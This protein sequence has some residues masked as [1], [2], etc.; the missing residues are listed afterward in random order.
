VI[1]RTAESDLPECSGV[2]KGNKISQSSPAFAD[3]GVPTRFLKQLDHAGVHTPFPIQAAVLPDAYAGR[4]IA[5][6]APT[7]SGKTLAFGLPLVTNVG[8]AKRRAPTGLVLA[9][10]RELAGQIADA[11]RPLAAVEGRTVTAVFGGVGYGPQR[12][13]LNN[14][15][16]IVVACPGRLEDL[17]DQRALRLDAVEVLVV[18]EADRMADMGFLPAIRRILGAATA[19]RQTMLF[20]ATLDGAVRK[21]IR[22]L[23]LDCVAHEIDA[24]EDELADTRHVFWDVARA[25]RVRH[26]ADVADAM[27]STFFFCRT[28]RGAD[29]LA[30]QLARLGVGAEPIHG[31]RSQGQR[32]RALESFKRGDIR[33]L[34]AT[35]VAARGIHVNDVAA[36]VH[37]DPPED[38]ATYLH[39]SGRTARAGATGV[40]VSFVD[41]GDRKTAKTF[42]R[43]LG[44]S[45]GVSTAS[46]AT[47]LL[48]PPDPGEP[49]YRRKSPMKGTTTMPTG[50]VKFF[51]AEKG[52]GFIS[53]SDGEDVFVHFSNIAGDGYRSLEDGQE[54]EFEVG[55]GRKG[56][57]ALNV[58][59]LS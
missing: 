24:D 50:T 5:G 11:L 45:P 54:V 41:A 38:Y 32:T 1:V 18:D 30:T 39:R 34:V 52:F 8:D 48:D 9:P 42:Q 28:R 22:E 16:D 15:V 21:L 13:A 6:R 36:V 10:T 7:G 26:A 4:N 49:E 23:A 59:P 40:V 12:K 53:R 35:D 25:D 3:L 14:G 27:S 55:P 46:T 57:E 17:L 31:G 56:P 20:S 37:F 43:E 33:A 58:R 51:N 19:T 47:L 2:A 29:R 44:I